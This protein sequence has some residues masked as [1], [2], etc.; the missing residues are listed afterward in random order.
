LQDRI[1]STRARVVAEYER[2]AKEL[3][4]GSED[5]KRLALDVVRFVSDMDPVTA[6]QHAELVDEIRQD[7]TREQGRERDDR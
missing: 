7:Q 6:T 5:D 4:K 2:A 3:A 1:S